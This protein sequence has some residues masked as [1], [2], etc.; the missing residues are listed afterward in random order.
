[1][2]TSK[3]KDTI[4]KVMPAVVSIVISKSLE[5]IEKELAHEFYGHAPLEGL[6]EIPDEAVD[7]HGM[8]KIGGGSG[9]V[10]NPNG[11]ILTNKHVVIDP[12]AEYMVLLNDGQ[13]LKAAVL[14][15]DPV[16]DIAI[17]KIEAVNLPTVS[18]GNSDNIELGEEILAIGNALGLFRNT[19]S[20]GIVSGLSRTIKAAPDPRAPVQEMRGLIQ[21][22]AAIN[23][24]NSGGPLVNLKGEAI[25]INAAI[26]YGAQNLSFALPIGAAKRDLEDLKKFGHIKRPL[27]G[28]RYVNVD[29][30]LKA[31]MKLAADYG[32]LV[33]GHG[34]R[35]EGVIPGSPA[36]VAGIQEKDHIIECNGEKITEEKT[37]Q[38]FLENLSVGDTMRLKLLRKGKP[39]ELKVVLAE[40]K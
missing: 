32:A 2:A 34:P 40:R 36:H 22:D 4:K 1:M 37:I 3:I 35:R 39:M 24:G 19:V 12:E 20:S 30:N 8:V 21:T 13:K 16:E 25:G 9:F 18:L 38:D 17:L 23:P 10:V 31:K 28:L 11:V 6:P 33:L 29:E 7:A 27:L 15:R 14:A 26:V 5:S